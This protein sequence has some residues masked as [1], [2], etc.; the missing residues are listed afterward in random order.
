MDASFPKTA[1][2]GIAEIP[3]EAVHAAFRRQRRSAEGPDERS[4]GIEDIELD[5]RGRFFLQMIIEDGSRRGILA[6][7][8]RGAAAAEAAHAVRILGREQVDGRGWRRPRKLAQQSEVVENPECSPLGRRHQIVV[9][10]RE[11]GDGHDGEVERE[12]LPV[13]A[14]VERDVDPGLGPDVQEAPPLHVLA[15]DANEARLRQV[16]VDPLPGLSG[17]PTS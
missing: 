11:I 8:G 14:V 13:E 4:G 16:P 10:D 17:S 12:R 2:I 5:R 9:L 3:L 1:G 7:P 15:N 6:Y